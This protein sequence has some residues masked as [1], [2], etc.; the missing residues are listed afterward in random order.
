MKVRNLNNGLR[1]PK[2]EIDFRGNPEDPERPEDEGIKMR[3]SVWVHVK[4][5]DFTSIGFY[6]PLNDAKKL[7]AQLGTAIAHAEGK[8]NYK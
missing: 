8:K 5:D 7:Y 3:P 2:I 1:N 6:T 4:P